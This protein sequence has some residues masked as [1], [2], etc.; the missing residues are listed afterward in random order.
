MPQ[1]SYPRLLLNLIEHI[2]MPQLVR[3]CP[4]CES[5]M[6][7]RTR[8]S[9]MV[10]TCGRCGVSVLNARGLATPTLAAACRGQISIF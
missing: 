8:R 9:L 3:L 1:S 5:P 4:S 6:Q 10:E 7:A 2:R